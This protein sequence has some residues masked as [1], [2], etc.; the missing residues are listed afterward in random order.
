M[1][2]TAAASTA[3]WPR[4]ARVLVAAALLLLAAALAWLPLRP[5]AGGVAAA[6]GAVLL[7]RRPWLVWAALGATLPFAAAFRLPGGASL[8]DLLLALALALWFADGVRRAR[9]G[10]GSP[11]LLSSGPAAAAALYVL[12]LLLS[13]LVARDLGQAATEVVKWVEFAALLLVLPAMVA[14]GQVQWVVAATLAGAAAQALLGLYQFFFRIGPDWFLVL[15]RYMRAGGSFAQPNPFAGYLGL[16][17]PVALSLMLAAWGVLLRREGRTRGAWAWAVYLSGVTA[18]LAAGLL[19]SWSRGGWLGAL[20]GAAA[21]VVLRSRKAA[22]AALVAAALLGGA[23][24]LGSLTPIRSLPEPVAER[25]RE[26][27][28]FF[29][30]G[31]VLAQEVTDENFALVE[32]VAHWVAALRMVERSPWIGVGPGNYAAFYPEVRLPRWEEPLGHAHNVYLNVL[33]EGG[34]VGGLA[35]A[36]LWLAA[37][38]F[39]WRRRVAAARQQDRWAAALAVGVAG[40]LAHLA[41]HSLVDNLFVQ[42]MYVQ[43]AL[44]LALVAASRS[45]FVQA[46]AGEMGT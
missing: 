46:A 13:A 34:I 27:P 9:A 38:V 28:A 45:G 30:A 26:V 4:G 3:T 29:G 10:T 19:A 36:V 14:R 15:G 21:V 40:V 37:G 44:W 25:L 1:G 41:V 11:R 32:R 31:D 23:L 2:M 39:V 16:V 18:L 20:A 12:A 24:L 7:L 22:L 8:L 5:A 33:A 6:A 43:I 42:G 35:F 17:L